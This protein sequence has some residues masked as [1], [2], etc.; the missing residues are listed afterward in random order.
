MRQEAIKLNMKLN[1]Y[2]LFKDN[3]KLKVN[4]EKDIFDYLNL[5]YLEPFERI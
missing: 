4:S 3:E 5:K 1:E 2:G